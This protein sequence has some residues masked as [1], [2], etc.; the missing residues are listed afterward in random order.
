MTTMSEAIWY[1]VRASVFQHVDI[2]EIRL[3]KPTI[4]SRYPICLMLGVTVEL[5]KQKVDKVVAFSKVRT[6]ITN[7]LMGIMCSRR[8]R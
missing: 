5:N 1:F 8:Y 2:R 4:A 3:L 7:K 6:Q